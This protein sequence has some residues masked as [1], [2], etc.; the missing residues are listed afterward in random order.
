MLNA[1]TVLS[2]EAPGTLPEQCFQLE[3]PLS[4]GTSLPMALQVHTVRG[5]YAGMP[6]R[7]LT[8]MRTMSSPIKV[9]K[10][11]LLHILRNRL[12]L[13]KEH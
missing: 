10:K 4:A 7:T 13:L 1:S 5:F 12:V 8:L 3:R 2:A 6:D 11:L 9:F